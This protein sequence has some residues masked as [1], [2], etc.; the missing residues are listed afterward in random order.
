MTTPT[1]PEISNDLLSAVQPLVFETGYEVFPYMIGG[2]AFLAGYEGRWYVCTTRHGLHP[3]SPPAICVFPHDHSRKFF[4]LG[5]VFFVPREH[6]P[7]DFVDLAVI[8]INM[9]C[10][11]DPELAV[12]KPL[13]LEAMFD[14]DWEHVALQ[15]STLIMAGYP[16]ERSEIGLEDQLLRTD[17]TLLSGTYQGASGLEH[18]HLMQIDDAQELASFDGFSGSPVLAVKGCA[19]GETSVVLCGMAIRGTRG[20]R[21]VHFLPIEILIEAMRIKRSQDQRMG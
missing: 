21:L 4:K 6:E 18:L 12:A 8:D 19:G 10:L 16:K 1:T 20:S 13:D 2:T 17:R 15:G 9:S 11:D 14:P 5:R 7:E 3:E